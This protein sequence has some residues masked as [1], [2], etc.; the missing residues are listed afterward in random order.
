M[1]ARIGDEIMIISRESHQPVREGQIWEVR[2]ERGGIVYLVQWSDTHHESLLPHGPDVVIKRRHT[3]GSEATAAKDVTW[4]SRLRHPLD[5]HHKR[6]LERGRHIAHERLAMRVE[7][8]LVGCGLC[9]EDYSIAAGRVYP[10]PRVVSVAD[11][12]PL[13][14]DVHMLPGQSPDD[15]SAHAATIAYD[16]GMAE[17]R[18]IPLGPSLIRLELLPMTS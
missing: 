17:I 18:T 5:W 1:T 8:I 14:V 15:F 16:L 4:L 7:E 10:F 11:G 13:S 2:N 6:D 9:H 3:R 12:P